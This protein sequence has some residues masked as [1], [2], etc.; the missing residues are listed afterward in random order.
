MGLDGGKTS[1]LNFSQIKICCRIKLHGN[2][3]FITSVASP[4]NNTRMKKK[5]SKSFKGIWSLEMFCKYD[6]AWEIP[7]SLDR[8]D[9]EYFRRLVSLD[10]FHKN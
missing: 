7:K 1:G 4:N 5:Y 6:R 8:L 10:T 9:L 2:N 3:I